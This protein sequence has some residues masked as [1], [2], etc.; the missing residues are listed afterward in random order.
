MIVE[1]GRPVIGILLFDRVEVL[2]FA[3]PFEVLAMS[4]REQGGTPFF[5]VITVAP[6]EDVTCEGGLSVRAGTVLETCPSLTALIV[7]GGPGAREVTED[8]AALVGFIKAQRER[9]KL[10]ASVCTGSYLLARAGLLDGKRATTHPWRMESF[11]AEFPAVKVITGK[12]VDEGEVITSGGVASG[13]DLALHLLE[14][15]E[16]KDARRREAWRLDGPW[17]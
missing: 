3:G 17:S 4:R 6:R 1:D 5:R 10:F 13:I 15:W 2:D 8:T 16:G 12:L 7:P 11:R 14:R 9:V